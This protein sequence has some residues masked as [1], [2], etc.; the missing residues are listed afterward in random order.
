[1]GKIRGGM[2]PGRHMCLHGGYS[3]GVAGEKVM[4]GAMFEDAGGDNAGAVYF[5]SP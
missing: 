3:V 4:V 2:M 1:M 5:F